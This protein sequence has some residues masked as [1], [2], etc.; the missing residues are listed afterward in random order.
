MKSFQLDVQQHELLCNL[1][2][3]TTPGQLPFPTQALFIEE[4]SL[5]GVPYAT[6]GSSGFQNSKILFQPY[7]VPPMVGA[8]QTQKAG[9]IQSIF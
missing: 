7:D 9:V 6:A 5:R 1:I 3:H 8:M 2:Q 4:I